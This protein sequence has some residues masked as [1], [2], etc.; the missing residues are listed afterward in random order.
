MP[1]DLEVLLQE[2]ARTAPARSCAEPAGA[3][4][5]CLAV[6][7]RCGEWL[8]SQGVE[9][10][11]MRFSGSRERFPEAS[12]RWPFCD[13]DTIGH[14]TMRVGPWSIDWSARQFSPDA[15]WPAVKRI[16][17]LTADWSQVHVWACRRCPELVVHPL[18]RELAPS[19]LEQEHRAVARATSGRGPF[20][21]PRHDGTPDP[22]SLCTCDGAQPY[23]A[24]AASSS[25]TV[26][27]P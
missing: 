7:A 2:F 22:K 20:P 18:H 3:Y 13:P 6:S 1:T 21:D 11:L 16:D 10:E 27:A 25:T 26:R 15:D 17:S 4:A 14:W 23:P 19:S 24:A 8:R 5:N 12:G 9:C